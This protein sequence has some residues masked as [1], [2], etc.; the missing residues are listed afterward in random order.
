MKRNLGILLIAGCCFWLLTHPVQGQTPPFS[1][2]FYNVENLFD[3]I[4][5]PLTND[6]E[7]LPDE[8]YKWTQERYQTKLNN[9]ARVIYAD[10]AGGYYPDIIGLCEIENRRVLEDLVAHPLLNSIYQI[11][12]YDSPDGRGIDVALL[13]RNAFFRVITSAPL[14]VLVPF[15]LDFRTRDILYVQGVAGE[16]TLHIYV[17]HWSSRRGGTE[18]SEPKRV[19]SAEVLRNHLDS[20]AQHFN[21]F[22]AIIMG[23]LNDEPHNRSV[24]EILGAIHP[25]TKAP[26][27]VTKPVLYNLAM[28]IPEGEGT[29]Y[30]WRDKKWNILDHIIITASLTNSSA[31]LVLQPG[32]F[33]VVKPDWLLKE[34]QGALIP[35]STFARDYQGGYSDHLPVK[36]TF[37]LSAPPP[38]PRKW[39]WRKR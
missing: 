34:D 16:D 37:T 17:N 4:D 22:H 1:V 32:S 8:R 14:Q 25:D 5:D 13:H 15:D 19:R 3:T 28:T 33:S 31:D 9:L 18:F 39:K 12:H 36:V 35:F 27:N 24:T 10:D 2:M 26:L 7:F 23:D 30:Y 6:E 38:P 20:V 11:V 21:K 29:Y